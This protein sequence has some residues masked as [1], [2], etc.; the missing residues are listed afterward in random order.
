MYL[1]PLGIT[2]KYQPLDLGLIAHSKLRYRSVL[3]RYG[4]NVIL[5]RNRNNSLISGSR[6]A[7]IHGIRAGFLPTVEDTMQLF[8]ESWGMTSCVTVMMWW[9]KSQFLDSNHV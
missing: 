3:L 2:A 7:A 9:I 6:N 8:N 5:N 4:I 1:L